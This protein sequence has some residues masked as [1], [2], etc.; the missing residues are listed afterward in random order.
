MEKSVTD[1]LL[2]YGIHRNN[3]GRFTR[4]GRREEGR[5][6]TGDWRREDIFSRRRTQVDTDLVRDFSHGG[7]GEGGKG[8]WFLVRLR[9]P[10]VF[11][12]YCF[13]KKRRYRICRSYCMVSYQVEGICVYLSG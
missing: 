9:V 5:Q 1:S 7:N 8:K 6:E 2:T 10:L 12:F 11:E 4:R 3:L 13:V